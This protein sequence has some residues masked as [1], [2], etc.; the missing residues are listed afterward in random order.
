MNKILLIIAIFI[1]A[2]CT[3]NSSS[4]NYYLTLDDIEDGSNVELILEIEVLAE[5]EEATTLSPRNDIKG[6]ASI[7]VSAIRGM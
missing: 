4:R 7:P 6:E 1:M 2:G 5:V 3:I